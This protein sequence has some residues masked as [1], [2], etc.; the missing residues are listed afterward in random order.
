MLDGRVV[1][2]QFRHNRLVVQACNG[3]L[4]QRG[5]LG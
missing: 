4:N 1:M 2:N 5:I 3:A